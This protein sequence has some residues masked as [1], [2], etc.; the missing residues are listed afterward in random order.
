[1]AIVTDTAIYMGEYSDIIIPIMILYSVATM[2]FFIF[3][4]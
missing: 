3:M 1:M 2:I 4:I